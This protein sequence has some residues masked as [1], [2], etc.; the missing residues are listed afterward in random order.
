MNEILSIIRYEPN[1]LKLEKVV[2][3]CYGLLFKILSTRYFLNLNRVPIIS[4]G[5]SNQSGEAAV[6]FNRSYDKYTERFTI[7]NF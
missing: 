4:L 7:S 6:N 2:A 5:L 3:L 1:K